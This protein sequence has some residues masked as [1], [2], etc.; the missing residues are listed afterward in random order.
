MRP[1]LNEAQRTCLAQ[2]QGAWADVHFV[3]IGALAH[4]FFVEAPRPTEGLDFALAVDRDDI[5]GLMERL[6]GW[7]R[8][9]RQEQRWYGPGTR[10]ERARIDIVPASRNPTPDGTMR[11]SDG[12]TMNLTGLDLALEHAERQ[13]IT[14]GVEVLVPPP[15]V[16]AYLKMAALLDRPER[17]K[18]VGDLHALVQGYL[19]DDD[20]RRW[21]SPLDAH[22]LRHDE[23]SAFAVGHALG[24]IALDPHRAVVERFCT[25]PPWSVEGGLD[26]LAPPPEDMSTE[27]HPMLEL[28]LRGLRAAS[29]P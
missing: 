2:L 24:C 7:S 21:E 6:E 26:R 29:S 10:R 5:P 4:G 27:T 13:L 22:A 19:P 23:Q 1:P 8:H 28:I 17:E 25:E 9:E 15:P 3:L 20:M 11:W 18:D 16:L 14:E 12:H